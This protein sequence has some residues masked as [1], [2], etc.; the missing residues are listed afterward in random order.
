[1]KIRSV[2]EKILNFFFFQIDIKLILWTLASIFVDKKLPK[3]G[4]KIAIIRQISIS[5]FVCKNML[6]FT[7]SPFL[8]LINKKNSKKRSRVQFLSVYFIQ[9]FLVAPTQEAVRGGGSCA[10]SF[11]ILFRPALNDLRYFCPFWV[12][13]GIRI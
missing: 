5:I 10:F 8:S 13:K 7:L 1:M 4:L 12:S 3:K 6:L 2:F 9:Y 11:V